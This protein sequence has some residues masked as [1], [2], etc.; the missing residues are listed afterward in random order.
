MIASIAAAAL[1]IQLSMTP[2]TAVAPVLDAP[3]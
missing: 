3:V 2:G 1:A